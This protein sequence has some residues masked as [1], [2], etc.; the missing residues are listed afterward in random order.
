[1]TSMKE[2]FEILKNNGVVLISTD[3]IPGISTLASNVEGVERI[4]KLKNR[5]QEKSFICL[6]GDINQVF[7]LIETPSEV[8][9]DIMEM[10]NRPTTVVMTGVRKPFKHL[11]AADDSLGIRLVQDEDL[12]QLLFKLRKPIVSTSI[13]V[14]GE[15]SA[16]NKAEVAPSILA[17][18]DACIEPLEPKTTR[19]SSIIKIEKDGQFKILRD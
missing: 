19:A 18:V 6:V 16:L 17:G 11:A 2:A 8:G 12:K 1:M 15:A 4:Q 3:S 14:S 5:P 13:N 9:L 7:D 10:A